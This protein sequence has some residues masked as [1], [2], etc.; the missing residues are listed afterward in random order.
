MLTAADWQA[1][2]DLYG[3]NCLACGCDD[4]PTIDHIVPVSRGGTN[5]VD[6]VQ[7]LCGD[8]N[9]R[10]GTKTIDYRPEMAVA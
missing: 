7:P 10:K 2:L 9:N 6:N 4:P 3:T 1:V 5:T 8:G